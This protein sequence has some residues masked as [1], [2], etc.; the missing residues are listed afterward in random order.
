M[1]L[2]DYPELREYRD[3]LAA[4]IRKGGGSPAAALRR[5]NATAGRI[6]G[7]AIREVDARKPDEPISERDIAESVRRVVAGVR[8]TAGVTEMAAPGPKPTP[9][10]KKRKKQLAEVT[11]QAASRAVTEALAGRSAPA[12]ARPVH[13]FDEGEIGAALRELGEADLA[14]VAEAALT[15]GLA[16]PFSTVKETAPA[17]PAT[18]PA[19]AP[20]KPLHEY[21]WET[22]EELISAALAAYGQ[23][24]GRVAPFW[25]GLDA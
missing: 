13:E 9:K 19:P 10:P 17:P 3:A 14:T 16:C 12:A 22:G 15:A 1:Q 5:A 2:T 24:A 6:H 4:K 18:Q 20:D 7:A 21:D 23:Q 11:G 8:R 25:A